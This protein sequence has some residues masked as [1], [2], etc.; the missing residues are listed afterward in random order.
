MG[1]AG[2]GCEDGTCGGAILRFSVIHAENVF[3]IYFERDG[4]SFHRPAPAWKWVGKAKTH[5][6]RQL[7]TRG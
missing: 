6:R 1:G 4:L 5:Y 7:L 2:G 3:P